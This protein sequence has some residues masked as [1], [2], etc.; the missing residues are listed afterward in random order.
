[1]T[2]HFIGAGPGAADLIT[3]RGARLI[4]G[5]PGRA[6]TPA[7]RAR[8]SCS[9]H[10]RA[11][12]RLVDTAD[13][14]L[15]ADHRRAGRRPRGAARTSP[16]CTP[17]TRRS[18]ARWPSRCA[19]STRP[20]SRTTSSPGVPAFAAA[21]AALKRE[22]TVPGR[23][24][25]GDPHPR[26]RPAPRRCRPARTSPRSAP[27]RATLVL[28]LA[29][30]RDRRGRRRA[31]PRTTAPTARSRW[32]PAPAGTTSWSCA[33]RWPTSPTQVRAAG[34]SRTAVIIVGA[35]LA[36]G[37]VPATATS[38][39]PDASGAA[40]EPARRPPRRRGRSTT[41]STSTG[42]PAEHAGAASR[43]PRRP[44]RRAAARPPGTAAA[45]PARCWRR[46]PVDQ[47]PAAA[48]V[49]RPAGQR[50]QVDLRAAGVQVEVPVGE[51]GQLADAAG[52]RQPRHRVAAQVLEH[53]AGEVA[54]VEQRVLGQAVQLG[55]DPLGGGA[56]AAG[57]VRGARR[58]G[59]RRCRA[60]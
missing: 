43:A 27:H 40:G 24:P 45:R 57:D 38:T 28:H 58:R 31:A 14:D 39:R 34:V 33:A 6:S 32:S 49:R 16:G 36:A 37:A 22:L 2:V 50:V 29:V 8:A 18:S 1:M 42:A 3:L 7:P 41:T 55:D 56:G 25:D 9:P 21:A 19:G 35:V 17:A 13:L 20:A 4:A 48:G 44:G 51:L 11:G 10:A 26:R 54:H 59:P 15:D 52:D 53:G 60:G 46:A 5:A 47:R 30:Q 12:A 23:R